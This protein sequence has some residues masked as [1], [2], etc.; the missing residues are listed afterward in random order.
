MTVMRSW[1]L[2]DD[3]RTAQDELA[4]MNRMPGLWFVHTRS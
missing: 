4:R 2:F 3:L 1:D